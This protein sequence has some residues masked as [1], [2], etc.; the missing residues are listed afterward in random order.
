MLC[1]LL[2]PTSAI[3]GSYA[4]DEDIISDQGACV[5]H[6]ESREPVGDDLLVAS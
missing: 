5:G 4:M 2:R 3:R 6:N 1:F